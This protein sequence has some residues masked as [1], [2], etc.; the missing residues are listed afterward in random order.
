[1]PYATM[2]IQKQFNL[3]KSVI[4]FAYMLIQYITFEGTFE[5]LTACF[6]NYVF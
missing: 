5:S 4:S 2:N 1:M 3:F 6:L